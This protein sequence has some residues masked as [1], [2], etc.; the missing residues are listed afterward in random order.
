MLGTKGK[1][2]S[3][4]MIARLTVVALLLIGPLFLSS[5][6]KEYSGQAITGT[7]VDASTGDPLEGVNVA[8]ICEITGGL[9]GGVVLGYLA[10]KEAVTDKSG[11]FEIPQWGPVTLER[12]FFSVRKV[13]AGEP[14]VVFYKFGYESQTHSNYSYGL[15]GEAPSPVR[16]DWDRQTTKLA[17]FDGPLK[18][19]VGHLRMTLDLSLRSVLLS[20]RQPCGWQEIPL[21][22]SSLRNLHQTLVLKQLYESTIYDE[23][24][25]TDK[26]SS[27]GSCQPPSALAQERAQ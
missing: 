19:Y 4:T 13:R 3:W 24:M 2:Y 18:D 17:H 14:S 10:V 8:M 25:T 23:L 7:V 9:E 21:M 22:I 16:S 6:A 12:S 1:R 15:M 11:K 26:T 20:S 5:C 27:N